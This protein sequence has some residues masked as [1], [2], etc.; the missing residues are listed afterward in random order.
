MGSMVMMVAS[1]AM[2]AMETAS[3][4]SA[5]ERKQAA[6]D[7]QAAAQVEELKRITG[8]EDEIAQE[9]KSDRAKEMDISL[10][11]LMAASADGGRTEAGLGR[12]AG[13]VAGTSGMD[14]GRIESNRQE[15]KSQRR[16]QSVSMIEENFAQQ[17]GTN[18]EIANNTM[19]FFGNAVGSAFTGFG[20]EAKLDSMFAKSAPTKLA[21]TKLSTANL[22]T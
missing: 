8:R 12:L 3:K 15:Q 5:L 17:Q 4:N 11:V 19:S 9:K 20:G 7:K 18:K 22:W 2:S 16:S 10:G 14:I 21:P 1:I 13:A 6:A